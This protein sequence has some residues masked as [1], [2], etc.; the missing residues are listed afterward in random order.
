MTSLFNAVSFGWLELTR[1]WPTLC[2]IR[3]APFVRFGLREHGGGADFANFGVFLGSIMLLLL[4]ATCAYFGAISKIYQT[5]LDVGGEAGAPIQIWFYGAPENDG[6]YSISALA[7]FRDQLKSQKDSDLSIAGAEPISEIAGDE[8]GRELSLRLAAGIWS[9]GRPSEHAIAE[10]HHLNM[11]VVSESSSLWRRYAGRERAAA[12]DELTPRLVL[13]QAE[14]GKY[15]HYDNYRAAVEHIAESAVI[16]GDW[17][18]QRDLPASLAAKDLPSLSKL[19]LKVNA[20][21]DQFVAFD[22]TWSTNF[23]TPRTVAALVPR[24]VIDLIDFAAELWR[25]DSKTRNLVGGLPIEGG[26]KIKSRVASLAADDPAILNRLRQAECNLTRN[27]PVRALAASQDAGQELKFDPPVDDAVLARCLGHPLDFEFVAKNDIQLQYTIYAQARYCAPGIL[28]VGAHPGYDAEQL[29]NSLPGELKATLVR[30]LL[31]EQGKGEPDAKRAYSGYLDAVE[32]YCGKGVAR[33][34]RD[35][36]LYVPP[37]ADTYGGLIMEFP[38]SVASLRRAVDFV[39]RYTFDPLRPNACASE[40]GRNENESVCV[41][42]FHLLDIQERALW[43]TV[44][45]RSFVTF[46][47]ATAALVGGW[48]VIQVLGTRLTA[49]VDRRIITYA[50]LEVAGFT[51]AHI[52]VLLMF[53]LTI[54]VLASSLAASGGF[55]LLRAMLNYLF[56]HSDNYRLALQNIGYDDREVFSWLSWG[57][58]V[59]LSL[60]VW[61]ATVAIGASSCNSKVFGRR[62]YSFGR[63]FSR[64]ANSP[65]PYRKQIIEN[66]TRAG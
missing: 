3:K 42:Q 28:I 9:E 5:V 63:L 31:A 35:E 65:R 53:Q 17:S 18:K 12:Q 16:A 1:E 62:W 43:K 29:A 47:G 60:A 30:Y 56:A 37:E 34:Q 58:R 44:I 54:V 49:L 57:M 22:V 11:L 33:V 27:L 20:G 66:L 55:E 23:Q 24:G 8:I 32:R 50:L 7:Q 21:N 46:V 48:L 10:P 52:V 2:L 45:L 61:L 6:L 26:G 19:V 41:P 39:N 15:F 4:I 14:F 25:E 36:V 13:N 59:E 38:Q 51:R 40:K 64:A